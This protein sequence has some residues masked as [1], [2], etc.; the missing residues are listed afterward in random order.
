MEKFTRLTIV[1][2][3]AQAKTA[4]LQIVKNPKTD[5]LFVST[6]NGTNFKCQQKID[7][8][9]PMEFLNTEGAAFNDYCLVNK[10]DNNVLATL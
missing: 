1:E 7:V 8:T 4:A 6:D 3:K 2:F 10:G 5:K 9:K